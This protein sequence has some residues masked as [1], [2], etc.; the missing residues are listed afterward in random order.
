MCTFFILQW[1]FI[2][3]NRFFQRSL[4]I[5]KRVTI[6]VVV[7]EEL[8][9]DHQQKIWLRGVSVFGSWDDQREAVLWE[10]DNDVWRL[11]DR[12]LSASYPALNYQGNGVSV[13]P[14]R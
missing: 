10:W 13:N 2:A 14:E 8:V 12:I 11:L 6:L 3:F 4:K 9:K 5:Q 1:D 7:G